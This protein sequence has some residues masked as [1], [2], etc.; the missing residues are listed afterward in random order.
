M[1]IL[2]C[3]FK[4]VHSLQLK[5]YH[6]VKLS[7]VTQAVIRLPWKP[8]NHARPGDSLIHT[9]TAVLNLVMVRSLIAIN[10]CYCALIG[11]MEAYVGPGDSAP[12]IITFGVG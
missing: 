9:I 7:S 2:H 1:S 6:L 3:L 12:C 5:C 11:K 4:K 8:S 10:H